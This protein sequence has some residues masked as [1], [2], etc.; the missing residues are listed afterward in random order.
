MY[1]WTQYCA[2]CGL[3][4]R[5][6]RGMCDIGKR[7]LISQVDVYHGNT[8]NI[9]ERPNP[10]EHITAKYVIFIYTSAPRLACGFQTGV[11]LLLGGLSS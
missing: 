4:G 7:K 2:R 3:K 1:V 6:W 5:N 8:W 10:S 9:V 11:G